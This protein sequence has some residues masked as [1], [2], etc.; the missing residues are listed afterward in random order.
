MDSGVTVV[1][2]E[3]PPSVNGKVQN[4]VIGMSAARHEHLV[5]SDSDVYAP[6]DYLKRM[7]APLADA[8][9]TRWF[10]DGFRPGHENRW[11]QVCAM[12]ANT[13]LEGY[14]GGAEAII[15]FDVLARQA[16]TS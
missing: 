16:A 13:S 3:S 4:M 11:Q 5:V 9:M 15:G 7:V 12:I 10:T 2:G 1:I 6:R 14:I 8:T